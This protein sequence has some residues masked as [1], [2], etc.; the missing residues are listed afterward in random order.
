[1]KE[2]SLNKIVT[3]FSR[4]TLEEDTASH[5]VYLAEQG[6]RTSRRHWSREAPRDIQKASEAHK[7]HQ[8]TRR[9]GR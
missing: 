6:R 9:Y 3:D 7:R 5:A 4:K 8:G 2:S 1:M